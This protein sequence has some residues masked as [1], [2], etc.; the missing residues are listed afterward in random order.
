MTKSVWRVG[1]LVFL[2]SIAVARAQASYDWSAAD[3]QPSRTGCFAEFPHTTAT[4]GSVVRSPGAVRAKTGFTAHPSLAAFAV[5]RAPANFGSPYFA[6]ETNL[7]AAQIGLSR[8]L[9]GRAPPF[10]SI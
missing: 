7:T 6:R 3:R 10:Q 1:V 2:L 5:T 8:V 9:R 4:L